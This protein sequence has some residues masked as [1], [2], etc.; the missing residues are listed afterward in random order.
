MRFF[1]TSPPYN[2]IT[3][4]FQ[5]SLWDST[6]RSKSKLNLAKTF[7]FSLWDSLFIGSQF[8]NYNYHF[9]FSLWDSFKLVTV[10]LLILLV[11]FNSLYEIRTRYYSSI[12]SYYN[13][14]FNSLYEIHNCSYSSSSSLSAFQFSLWDSSTFCPFVQC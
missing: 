11:T 4:Y 5:F 8:I 14:S 12:T 1:R 7:Q 2:N 13:L 3:I 10:L 6:N 9:Q